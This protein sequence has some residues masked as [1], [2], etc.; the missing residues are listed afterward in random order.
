MIKFTFLSA[1]ILF[2]VAGYAQTPS[3]IAAPGGGEKNVM[4]YIRD[5]TGRPAYGINDPGIEGTPFLDKEEQIGTVLFTNGKLTKDVHLKFDMLNNKIYFVRD[6]TIMEFIDTVKDFYLQY[7]DNN[8]VGVVYRN[9]F[10]QIDRNTAATYYE[11]LA[12]GKVSLLKHRYKVVTEYK[13]YSTASKK[14]YD[15]RSQ[16]YAALPGDRIIRIRKDRKFLMDAMPEYA[17]KIKTITDKL[18]LKSDE[19]LIALFQEL[20]K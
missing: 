2:F 9:G 18:K 20:N 11:L 10:P 5:L 17:D 19:S 7:K 1:S 8:T 14:R 4:V 3:Y 13:E 12:D 15:E 6:G 16:L